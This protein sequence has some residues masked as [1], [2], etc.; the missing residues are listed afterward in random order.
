MSFERELAVALE[1]AEAAGRLILD[2]YAR[3]VAICPPE[4]R[5]GV[6]VGQ[7]PEAPMTRNPKGLHWANGVR[8]R[9]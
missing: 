5:Y 7:V 6:S 9:S 2:R 4:W 8:T 1:A 3:F